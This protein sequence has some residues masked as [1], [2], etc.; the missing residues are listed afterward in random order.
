MLAALTL[1][2]NGLCIRLMNICCQA[3]PTQLA[4]P[5]AYSSLI[6]LPWESSAEAMEANKGKKGNSIVDVSELILSFDFDAFEYVI[7]ASSNWKLYAPM[8]SH[9]KAFSERD[10]HQQGAIVS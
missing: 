5:S 10:T 2:P 8:M 7:A 4:R 3:F 9:H 6:C 1:K